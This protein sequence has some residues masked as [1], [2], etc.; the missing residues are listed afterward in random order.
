LF[1]GIGKV[2]CREDECVRNSDRDQVN[3]Q[4]YQQEMQHERG[5]GVVFCA[6]MLDI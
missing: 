6:V 1:G 5:Q 2:A 4:E 3:H